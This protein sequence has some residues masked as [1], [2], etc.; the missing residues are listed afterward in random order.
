MSCVVMCLPPVFAV[1]LYVGVDL[2]FGPEQSVEEGAVVHE[3]LPRSFGARSFRRAATGRSRVRCGSSRRCPG[4]RPRCRRPADRSRRSG[5][6]ARASPASPGAPRGRLRPRA[7]STNSVCTF[8]QV[9]MCSCRASGVRSTMSSFLR[10]FSR[11]TRSASAARCCRRAPRRCVRTPGRNAPSDAW[12]ACAVLSDQP[13]TPTTT[14]HQDR[15]E[16]P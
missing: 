3:R 4:G 11:A 1:D 6:R 12:T 14:M 7:A 2:G 15:D 10:F 16:N 8:C 5:S 9:A 13:T